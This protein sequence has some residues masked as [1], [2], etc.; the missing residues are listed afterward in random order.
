MVLPKNQIKWS[1][2]NSFTKLILKPFSFLL[3]A[4]FVTPEDYGLI[5][6]A[7]IIISFIEMIRERSF[8]ESYIKFYEN[9]MIFRSTLI[10]FSIL[11]GVFLYVILYVLSPYIVSFVSFK[12]NDLLLILQIVSLQ[13]IIGSVSSIYQAHIL[14]DMNY[15]L[16]TII[17]FFPSLIPFFVT[18][19]LA[20]FGFGVWALVIGLILSNVFRMVLL[21]LQITLDVRLEI[22]LSVLRKVITFMK[23]IFLESFLN[24]FYMWGDKAILLKFVSLH[25][26]GLYTVATQIIGMAYGLGFSISK[27]NYAHLCNLKENIDAIKLYITRYIDLAILISIVLFFF[28]YIF[29][30]MLENILSEEWAGISTVLILL[31]ITNSLSYSITEIVPDGLK[32]INKPQVIPV[33]QSVKLLYTIPIF[34]YSA[35]YFGFQGFLYGKI[36]TVLIGTILFYFIGMKYLEL[37]KL[38]VMRIIKTHILVLLLS[39]LIYFILTTLLCQSYLCSIL[40][41]IVYG[42]IFFMFKKEFV[43]KNFNSIRGN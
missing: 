39:Y 26:L 7:L 36:V 6:F 33:L 19:P 31:S 28:F 43:I 22:K 18:I 9:T 4:K 16:L 21:I 10:T 32:S 17:E 40:L 14:K 12:N 35:M 30:F 25:E 15:K 29:S 41:I 23:Y 13:I 5:T 2:I 3:I 20:Y 34:L 1:Y 27:M 8:S 11:S 37:N 42:L 38:I 24:W